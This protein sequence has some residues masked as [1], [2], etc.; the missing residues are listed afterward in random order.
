MKGHTMHTRTHR[1][2][3][4]AVVSGL[5][6]VGLALPASAGDHY[7]PPPPTTST[8]IPHV[9]CIPEHPLPLCRSHRSHSKWIHGGLG[10][11]HGQTRFIETEISATSV[12]APAPA[13]PAAAV[14]GTPQ[15]T[16]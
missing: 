6:L 15:V 4:V 10:S 12:V 13:P 1:T 8:T 9:S 5:A 16:G 11:I 3:A 14:P 2:I 7:S